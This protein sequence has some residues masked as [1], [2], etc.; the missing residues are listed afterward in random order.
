MKFSSTPLSFVTSDKNITIV[1]DIEEHI[2]MLDNLV[3][4]IVFTP[5]GSFEADPDFGFEYWNHEFSNINYREFNNDY[6]STSSEGLYNEITKKECQDSIRQS[7][8]VYAPQ[9]KNVNVAIEMNIASSD[10]QEQKKVLS[11]YLI[12]V[13]VEAV[14]DYGMSTTVAY[15]KD[16]KFLIEPTAKKYKI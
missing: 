10:K 3:D 13:I 8:A 9:L 14:I 1:R 15:K 4:L 11:K 7:L 16:V 6:N 2:S 5:R 12:T